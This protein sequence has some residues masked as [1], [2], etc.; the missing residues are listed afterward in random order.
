MPTY[1]FR[2]KECDNYFEVV[3]SMAEKAR[4]ELEHEIVCERCGGN[5]VEQVFGGF[6]ILSG[7]SVK[8]S[9]ADGGCCGGGTCGCG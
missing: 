8:G 2:C 1:E 6:S 3:T 7:M 5:D 4:R 9:A